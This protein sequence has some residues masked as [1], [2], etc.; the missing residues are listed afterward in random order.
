MQWQQGCS[1]DLRNT[2]PTYDFQKTRI[3]EKHASRREVVFWATK[4]RFLR[5]QSGSLFFTQR[6]P[7]M[8]VRACKVAH[9]RNY[10]KQ[11]PSFKPTSC[12]LNSLVCRLCRFVYFWS[13]WSAFTA[14]HPAI[15]WAKF[16]KT[17]V[18]FC[19]KV[20]HARRSG[21]LISVWHFFLRAGKI[22]FPPLSPDNSWLS[23]YLLSLGQSSSGWPKRRVTVLP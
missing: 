1:F 10:S 9:Q 8:A 18:K 2:N 5:V 7:T 4:P 12:T 16:A 3:L 11:F 19:K 17:T 14:F 21:R 6:T 23:F 20:H 15:I 13:F 22:Q